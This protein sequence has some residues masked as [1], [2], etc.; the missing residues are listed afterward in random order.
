M[1]AEGY[2]SVS[3]LT[4]SSAVADALST[5]LFCMSVEDGKSVIEH[6]DQTEAMWVKA[7]GEIIYSDGFLNF[8][9]GDNT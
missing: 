1:P 8:T 5:A 4:E 9:K 6:F 7:N 2:T 3:I